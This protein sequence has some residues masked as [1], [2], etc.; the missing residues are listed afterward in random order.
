MSE[1]KRVLIAQGLSV[2]LPS[3]WE[4]I[5][6][7]DD[8]IAVYEIGMSTSTCR[9]SIELLNNVSMGPIEFISIY[10][11][12]LM[13]NLAKLG[14]HIQEPASGQFVELIATKEGIEGTI[15]HTFVPT[16]PV[17]HISA[18][19][20]SPTDLTE[21]RLIRDSIQLIESAFEATQEEVVALKVSNEWQRSITG[22]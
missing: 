6:E 13:E 20:Q 5:A 22:G 3:A 17:T 7:S 16:N 21:L 2:V 10:L 19:Y 9:A 12:S 8:G 4:C 15:F 14:A 18:I 1:M 11:F